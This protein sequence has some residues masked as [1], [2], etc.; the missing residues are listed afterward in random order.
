M[1]PPIEVT[2]EACGAFWHRLQARGT[3]D[4]F[5]RLGMRGGGCSGYSYVVEYDDDGPTKNSQTF[6]REWN[7]N[8]IVD[9][10]CLPFMSGSRLVHRKTFMEEK[11]EFENPRELTRCSCGTSFTAKSSA[12]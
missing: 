6:W 9:N 1:A 7:V 3:P 10:R 5:I 4:A 12:T 11:F 8:F 2:P